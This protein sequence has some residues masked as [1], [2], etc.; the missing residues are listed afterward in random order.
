MIAL[1]FAKA[2]DNIE[3]YCGLRKAKLCGNRDKVF[4]KRSPR[5]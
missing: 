1:S 4:E 3:Y 5:V 2:D